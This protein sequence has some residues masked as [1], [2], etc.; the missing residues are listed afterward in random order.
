MVT[1]YLVRHGQTYNNRRGIFTGQ[2]DS[3]L[4]RKGQQQIVQLS[5]KLKNIHFDLAYQSGL[6]RSHKTL[7]ILLK[8]HNPK[9]KVITDIRLNERSYGELEQHYHTHTIAKYGLKQFRL[10][11]RDFDIRPPG[12]ESFADVEIRVRQFL[13]DLKKA[14]KYE[15]INVLIS[16]HGNSIR[17]MRRILEHASKKKDLSLEYNI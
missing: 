5:K 1:L 9:P 17:L 14:H 6:K 16:A 12:G 11:H 8:S 3:K 10:W 15:R 2:H 13:S 7:Q 4:T